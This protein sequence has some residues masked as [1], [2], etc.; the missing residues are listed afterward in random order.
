MSASTRST[1]RWGRA[2]VR[3][4]V[5]LLA[6]AALS[7]CT[8]VTELDAGGGAGPV[9]DGADITNPL[10]TPADLAEAELPDLCGLAAGPLV[11]GSRADGATTIVLAE[12]LDGGEPMAAFSE[13][14]H[15]AA[16]AFVTC[17]VDGAALPT[18]LVLWNGDLEPIG[19][20]DGHAVEGSGSAATPGT[21]AIDADGVHV[22]W[23]TNGEGRSSA[24]AWDAAMVVLTVGD[25]AITAGP[26]EV[27]R[28]EDVWATAIE[29]LRTTGTTAQPTRPEVPGLVADA[30]QAFDMPHWTGDDVSC[31]VSPHATDDVSAFCSSDPAVGEP[32]GS[33]VEKVGWRT[34]HITNF[35]CGGGGD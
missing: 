33:A 30:E 22:G 10:Y 12:A 31:A 16:A 18:Q 8:L 13:G 4:A 17:D 35:F 1:R 23:N 34:W 14:G 5:V 19:S 32:C 29:D 11:G 6:A 20:F 26:L 15:V 3:A 24:Y 9:G 21:V 25:G 28:A 7:G 2:S 27:E